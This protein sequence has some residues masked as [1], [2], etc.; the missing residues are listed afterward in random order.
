MAEQSELPLPIPPQNLVKGK[1]DYINNKDASY[2]EMLVNAY[3]S[4]TQTETWSF[5]KEGCDSFMFSKDPRVYL[6]TNKMAALGY[7]GHS[8][9]SFGCVMRDMQ[10]I[11]QNGEEKFR[12]LY[13][14]SN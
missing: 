3:Q 12:E 6:I 5:V 13:L 2:K 7:D 9:C 10:Y 8:G 14:T 1:F 11:A 4:I